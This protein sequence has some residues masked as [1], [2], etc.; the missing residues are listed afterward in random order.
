MARFRLVP[1]QS[2]LWAE[3]SSALHRVRVHTTGLT[4]VLEAQL[5]GNPPVLSAPTQV[6]LATVRLR[7]GNPMVDGELQKRIDPRA[8]PTI[9]AEMVAAVVSP[10]AGTVRITGTLSFHGVTRR[11][12]VEVMITRPEPDLL[13]LEGGRTI[14][15]RDFALPPPS[16]LMFRMDPR[17]QVRARLV[18]VREA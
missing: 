13:V 4:G 16:F 15:M 9:R 3:A 14:D 6:E 17:V 8:H 5:E 18:A 1:E 11:L 2:E 10:A 7:S 12:E